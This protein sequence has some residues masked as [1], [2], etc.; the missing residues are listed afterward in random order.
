MNVFHVGARGNPVRG[1]G[2]EVTVIGFDAD[3]NE[4][5][6]LQKK[7]PNH[8]FFGETLGSDDGIH[9]LF[10][11]ESP[12]CT[13]LLE[14]LPRNWEFAGRKGRAK[15][16]KIEGVKTRTLDSW[17]KEHEI[18][19]DFLKIDVQG[20]ELNILQGYKDINRV[21]GIETEVFF[22]Y[23]YLGQDLFYKTY[24]YLEQRGFGLYKLDQCLWNERLVFG[25]AV[26][27]NPFHKHFDFFA[28]HYGVDGEM[29][30]RW[31]K[32]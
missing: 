7:Y 12:A 18:Y 32:K 21:A 26:F 9:D 17:C 15:V 6:R 22:H 11:T 27:L 16:I 24:R 2:K 30:V 8:K 28:K 5:D 4:A 29:S 14:P 31:L 13:S 23:L 3:C 1:W 20:Y 10:I 25:D 19:P